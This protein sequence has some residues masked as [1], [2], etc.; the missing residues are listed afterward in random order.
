M[1]TVFILKV[2]MHGEIGYYDGSKNWTGILPDAKQFDTYPE[3][4]AFLKH[5]IE[6]WHWGGFI[7]IEKYF[8][9][10]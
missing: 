5:A 9:H 7:Q 2:I 4:E 6:N 1:K 8:T 3:A 10:V